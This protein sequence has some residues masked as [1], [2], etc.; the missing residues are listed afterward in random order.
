VFEERGFDVVI[1]KKLLD[2]LGGVRIDFQR[3]PWMGARFSV[4]PMY[5]TGTGGC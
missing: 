5:Q 1:E 4:V 2:R 3:Q